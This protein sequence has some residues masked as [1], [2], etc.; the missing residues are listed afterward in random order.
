MRSAT[1]CGE[2]AQ[3]RFAVFA[4]ENF[5]EQAGFEHFDEAILPVID[6]FF[7][8]LAAGFEMLA[9][10]VDGGG[11]IVDAAIFR[12][13]GANDGRM[14]AIAGHDE[15]EHGVKL[16]FEAISA[17]AIGFVED[18]NIANFHQAGFHV[19]DVVAEAGDEDDENA[20]GETDDI[21]FV[22]A[23]ADGFDE[24]LALACGVE[25]KRNFSG[26]TS[27]AAEESARGHGADENAGVAGVA[28]HAN[29]IAENS[30]AGV[31]AGGIDG[32]DADG[33]VAL[34]MNARRGDRLACSCRCRA[35]R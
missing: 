7:F 18:E 19:L 21:D 8:A 15:R 17:F 13:D 4:A 20:I 29:A 2:G 9:E 34:A 27:Q 31:G 26:G 10:F 30:A 16:L 24:D 5:F 32:D 25:E 28:L 14:P 3:A 1:A 23:D 12:G 6:V 33:L 22:L 35:R 11:E